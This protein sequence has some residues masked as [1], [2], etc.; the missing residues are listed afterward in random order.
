MIHVIY[1][2]RCPVCVRTIQLV[3]YREETLRTG[4]QSPTVQLHAWPEGKEVFQG[5]AA[6]KRPVTLAQ[7]VWALLPTGLVL[8]SCQDD[9]MRLIYEMEY[10]AFVRLPTQEIRQ[11]VDRVAVLPLQQLK[12]AVSQG[13]PGRWWR[14][15]EAFR[16]A[17]AALQKEHIAVLDEFLPEDTCRALSLG[18]LA[19]RGEMVRGATGAAGKALAKGTEELQKVLNEPSR[20]DVVKFS[21]DGNMPGCP[22]FLEA[23]DA[24]VEGLQG[25]PAVADRLQHVDWANGAMFAIYPGDSSRYIKHVDNTLGTDGRRLTAV[26]YLNK[27]WKPEHG[28]CLRVFEPTMQS[29]QVKC[30]VEPVWNRLVVFW[31]TQEVPHEVLSSFK[32]RL[33]V[34]VWFICGRES[35]RNEESFQRLF[36]PQKLRCIGQRNRR[37]CLLRAAETEDER[38]ALRELPLEATFS[39]AK[40]SILSRRF[41]WRREE[42]VERER[43]TVQ[44][45]AIRNAVAKALTGQ[46]PAAAFAATAEAA[47]PKLRAEPVRSGVPLHFEL[48]E[49]SG[50]QPSKSFTHL[51][52]RRI[53]V[54]FGIVD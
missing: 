50:S 35:L 42:D 24:L 33:A 51:P 20:G 37:A 21:D 10:L 23:L 5:L 47:P 30:D 12:Q 39:P 32:D 44:D 25:C 9:P 7:R 43:D 41:R 17:A 13:G 28:G 34:S 6:S 52:A 3:S 40:L 2:A 45:V 11:R 36:N 26:L 18:A 38:A 16:L 14:H 1:D 53:P 4:G 15:A 8:G 27:D 54:T 22:G 19:S 48:V 29:C 49:D 31:S 46:H